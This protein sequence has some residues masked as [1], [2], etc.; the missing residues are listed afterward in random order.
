MQSILIQIEIRSSACV[1]N[2]EC[3]RITNAKRPIEAIFSKLN[4]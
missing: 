4:A 2:L 1:F 3:I